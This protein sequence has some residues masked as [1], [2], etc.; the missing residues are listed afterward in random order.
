MATDLW[1]ARA[2]R[3]LFR[4]DDQSW[5]RFAPMD[6]RGGARIAKAMDLS[7]TGLAFFLPDGVPANARPD[8]GDVV[9]IEFAPPALGPDVGTIACFATVIRVEEVVDW[10]PE[11]GEVARTKV[12]VQFRHM[13]EAHARALQAALEPIVGLEEADASLNAPSR[14][15]VR[16]ELTLGALA[17]A[18]AVFALAVPPL[19][20][21]NWVRHL[22]Q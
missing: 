20:L 2:P 7:A 10:T 1:S 12:A 8:E 11:L 9:K 15:R 14:W 13:P 4:T 5:M 22:F 3:F 18:A 21:G 19:W 17:L 6:T 16:A